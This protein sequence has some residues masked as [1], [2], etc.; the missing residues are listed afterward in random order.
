MEDLTE[1]HVARRAHPARDIFSRIGARS[2][3]NAHFPQRRT[4]DCDSGQRIGPHLRAQ[5]RPCGPPGA[6]QPCRVRYN[7]G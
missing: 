2:T 5:A 3:W 4:I 7:F 1:S 6:R